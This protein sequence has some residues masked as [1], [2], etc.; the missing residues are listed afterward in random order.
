MAAHHVLAQ[1]GLTAPSKLTQQFSGIQSAGCCGLVRVVKCYCQ[2]LQAAVDNGKLSATRNFTVG[3]VASA[4]SLLIRMGFNTWNY[5]TDL[6]PWAGAGIDLSQLTCLTW[7][8]TDLWLP[9]PASTDNWI[10]ASSAPTNKLPSKP[11][12]SDSTA[13]WRRTTSWRY[14]LWL[15]VSSTTALQV[16][17][18]FN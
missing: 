12:T 8:F 15:P 2:T 5:V 13:N 6:N 7:F 9:V 1:S 10:Q 4:W 16:L 11:H 18:Y 17:T 3:S 14:K